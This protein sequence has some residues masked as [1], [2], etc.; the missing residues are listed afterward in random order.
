ML[1]DQLQQAYDFL[2]DRNH[3]THNTYFRDKLGNRIL[4]N[5]ALEYP[6][7]VDSACAIGALRLS[8]IRAEAN[9]VINKAIEDCFPRDFLRTT[10]LT[11]VKINDFWGYDA[12]MKVLARAIEIA[13]AQEALSDIL[14]ADFTDSREEAPVV[15]HLVGNVAG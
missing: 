6:N 5:A 7:M 15:E 12:V 13:K 3:W 8:G 9:V 1:S 10:A 14:P 4:T 2:S 11:L